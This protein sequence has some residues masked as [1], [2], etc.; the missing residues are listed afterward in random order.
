M[1]VN[2]HASDPGT[3]NELEPAPTP[4][5]EPL[6]REALARWEQ[7]QHDVLSRH[8]AHLNKS[9]RGN[10]E[11]KDSAQ[12]RH[13]TW[14]KAKRLGCK[15][16]PAA[17]ELTK[18]GDDYKE[19]IPGRWS[20]SMPRSGHLLDLHSLNEDLAADAEQTA[21][22][23]FSTPPRIGLGTYINEHGEAV[24]SLFGPFE[25][26]V[27]IPPNGTDDED[28]LH[29]YTRHNTTRRYAT[30]HTHHHHTPHSTHTY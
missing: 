5:P 8:Q 9:K 25:S 17:K 27:P 12:P 19:A 11:R 4:K 24:S 26:D 23:V 10:Q 22:R 13:E 2:R 18:A 30:Q 29:T 3:I 15:K 28:R 6:S 14:A 7:E 20:W 21:G 1:S 16:R